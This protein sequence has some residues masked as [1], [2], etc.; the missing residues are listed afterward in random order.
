[1]QNLLLDYTT[2]NQWA[3]LRIIQMLRPLTD[4]QFE[5]EIISSFPSVKSTL[6]H[7][8]DAQLIWLSRMKGSSPTFFPSEAFV[9]GRSEVIEGLENNTRAYLQFVASM[10]SAN[11]LE[12]CSFKTLSGKAMNQ[13]FAELIL[14]CMNHSTYHRGQILTMLRQ[15]EFKDFLPTD[16]IFYLREKGG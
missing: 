3:N 15:L 13:T 5:K 14:H 16:Y 1:M 4:E 9:G 2:Y 6:L 8:W 7:I 10:N 11:F 12:I